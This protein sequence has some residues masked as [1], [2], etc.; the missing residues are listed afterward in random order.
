MEHTQVHCRSYMVVLQEGSNSRS[1]FVIC[2][3][4]R[5]KLEIKRFCVWAYCGYPHEIED[6]S[7]SLNERVRQE[8]RRHTMQLMSDE[9]LWDAAE[10]Q[11]ENSPGDGL[12]V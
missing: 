8:L 10:D 9:N 2:E 7:N 4:A 5:T 12:G 11:S 1:R 6:I 3:V